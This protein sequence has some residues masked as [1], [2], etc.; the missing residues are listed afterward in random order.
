MT[1]NQKNHPSREELLDRLKK[2]RE[3]SRNNTNK[4]SQKKYSKLQK[5]VKQQMKKMKEDPRI[6]PEM[7]LYHKKCIEEIPNFEIPSPLE[8]LN[9]EQN[10]REQFNSYLS[11]TIK[12]CADNNIPKEQ[13]SKFI[14]T[15]QENG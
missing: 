2:Q 11:N 4:M 10:A 5:E 9:N 8:L 7:I 12:S 3:Y 15:R 6:T 1:D 13:F 14:R